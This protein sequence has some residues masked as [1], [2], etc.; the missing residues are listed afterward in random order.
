MATSKMIDESSKKSILERLPGQLPISTI[1][2][3]GDWESIAGEILKDLPNLSTSFL[4]VDAIWRDSFALTGTFRT[5]YFPDTIA[6]EWSLL[7]KQR[8]VLSAKLIQGSAKIIRI[9]SKHAW[10]DCKFSF[11]TTNPATECSGFLS[12]VPS[13]GGKWKIWLLR[14]I[15][16]QITGH[17]DVDSLAPCSQDASTISEG[18]NLDKTLDRHRDGLAH[19][20]TNGSQ[21]GPT[22]GL[23]GLDSGTAPN[24]SSTYDIYVVII[25]GGQSG[26]GIGGRLQALGVPYVILEQHSSVGDAWKTRYASARLHTIREYSHLPFDRTFG[27]SYPEYLGKDDLAEGHRAWAAKY[28][29]NI[30]L[31]TTVDSGHWD[32]KTQTYTLNIRRMGKESQVTAKHVIIATGAGS[33]TP[34]MPMFPN[35]EKYRGLVLH[36]A[37]YVSANEWKRKKGIVIGTANTGHDVASDMYDAGMNTTMVQRNR[38]YVLPVEYIEDRY[39]ALYNDKIPTEVSDR[40]MFS[41]P[42]SI[43][44]LTSAE[45]LHAMARAQ[46]ERWDALER[47]GFKVDPYGDIQEA[48]LVRLGGHYIDVGTSAKISNGL[49]KVK[50]DSSITSYTEDGLLFAD[51]T[52]TK[53]DVIVFAT[54]F[55]GNLK[56][57]AA[58]L[59]GDEVAERAG[60]FFGLDEEGEI[61]G[62]FKPTQ[63]P[64]FW[65]MGG[66]LGHARYHSR[67]L[68]LSIKA[69]QLGTALPV[70]MG[71]PHR[72]DSE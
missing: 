6:R 34:V 65:Y 40:I 15:L 46:P 53:A 22:N 23:P 50:S 57:R 37:Q 66:A 28:G 56:Q 16:E 14:T 20:T 51:G 30:W 11:T 12:L 39:H 68:A 35:R 9:G 21:N 25:G 54:G 58:Q 3:V 2:E 55:V 61:V 31:S 41:N 32:N 42:I 49:I 13:E 72:L 52:E 60:N 69:H 63:Q 71:S 24:G 64:G 4:A 47:A 17:G 5:F 59:F 48:I 38:T 70:Y 67:F 7:C 62:A 44:R 19:G 10:L 45:V 33:H 18:R 43:D 36:S 1:P 29:I 8:G 26:L 27:P